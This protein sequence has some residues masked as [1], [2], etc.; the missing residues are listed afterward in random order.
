M[1]IKESEC[2]V[3]EAV[4]DKKILESRYLNYLNFISEFENKKRW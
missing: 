4:F 2:N 1:H 3:K